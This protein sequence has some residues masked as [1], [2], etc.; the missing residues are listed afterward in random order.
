[1]KKLRELRTSKGYTYEE[2][3]K[4]LGI[5]KPFYWEIENRKKRLSYKMAVK[6]ALLL[7]TT[8]DE[9]FYEL[10]DKE[11]ADIKPLISD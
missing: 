7:D 11:T 2:F 8:P 10:F 1:M 4:M 5:S 9:L 3:G 6:I